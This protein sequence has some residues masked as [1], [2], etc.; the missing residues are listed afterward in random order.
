[1]SISKSFS[2]KSYRIHR[3]AHSVILLFIAKM[4]VLQKKIESLEIIE[5]CGLGL[6]SA[7]V[8][9]HYEVYYE[10]HK[11]CVLVPFRRPLAVSEGGLFF[12]CFIALCSFGAT[13]NERRRFLYR[14][15]YCAA[16][17]AITILR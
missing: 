10:G 6:A 4:I 7:S 2:D 5:E 12:D 14:F 8:R 17:R 13:F 1:M 9:G 11:P 3:V 16:T 15:F